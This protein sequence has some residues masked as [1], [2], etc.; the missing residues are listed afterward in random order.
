[1]TKVYAF[2][3]TMISF[4]FHS[5][6]GARAYTDSAQFGR[7]ET[8]N[9]CVNLWFNHVGW[10]VI[11]ACVT[12]DRCVLDQHRLKKRSMVEISIKIYDLNVIFSGQI[13]VFRSA[14]YLM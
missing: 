4:I 6:E 13:R 14:N 9:D 3:T 10:H 12:V 1:M 11:K 5:P 2:F 8:V 7:P